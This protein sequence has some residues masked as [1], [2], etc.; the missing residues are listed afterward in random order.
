MLRGES[1][2]VRRNSICRVGHICRVGQRGQ[3]VNHLP[4]RSQN[5]LMSSQSPAVSFF[6]PG[7][8]GGCMSSFLPPVTPSPNI[9]A[10]LEGIYIYRDWRGVTYLALALVR[11]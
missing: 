11:Y 6:P 10:L 5:G 2:G 9:D 8:F 4:V 1:E 7:R 3:G